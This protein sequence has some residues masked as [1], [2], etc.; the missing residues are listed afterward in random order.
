MRRSLIFIF[1][2]SFV[3]FFLFLLYEWVKG[4]ESLIFIVLLVGSFLFTF[5]PDRF[6]RK[7]FENWFV[8][9]PKPYVPNVLYFSLL[10]WMGYSIYKERI[11]GEEIGF[12]GFGD[13]MGEAWI[14]LFFYLTLLAGKRLEI[15][16]AYEKEIDKKEKSN[17]KIQSY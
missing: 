5:F 11:K 9:E 2:V 15:W 1:F 3:G 4:R 8:S 16:K 13:F 14:F 17:R 12:G 6:G 10:G 7:R